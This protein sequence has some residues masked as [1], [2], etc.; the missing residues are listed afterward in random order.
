MIHGDER[1][2]LLAGVGGTRIGWTETP[3]LVRNEIELR[4]QA[5]VEHARTRDPG[6]SPALAA[7]L[8]LSNGRSV[9][10]KA[11][12]PD[13]ISG[14]P[15]GQDFYRREAEVSAALSANVPAPRL[16]DSWEAHGWVVLVLERI[17]GHNPAFPCR[18]DELD[19]VLGA[20]KGLAESLT[21]SAIA[22]PPA[23]TILGIDSYWSLLA[24]DPAA[25]HALSLDFSVVEHLDELAAVEQRH[26]EA[27]AGST[28]IHA[29]IRADNILL[30]ADRV[31]FVDWPGASIGA[32]WLDLAY[33]LPSVAMQGGPPA[34]DCFREH[35]LAAQVDRD[36]LRAVVAH[37]AGFM[38]QRA[39]QPPL[40]GIPRLREFQLAQGLEAVAW[41]KQL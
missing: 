26:S 22:A 9:F 7:E 14:A 2:Q 40:R 33:F 21:P 23:A 5:R 28:L 38:L 32:P 11:I 37:F 35:P 15:G 31:V 25:L 36:A 41:L 30:T 16:L 20:M 12:A 6:F 19:R 3:V 29:D 1:D 17:E 39:T 34:F 8:A 27:A 24:R 10:V 13:E 18:T 4:L